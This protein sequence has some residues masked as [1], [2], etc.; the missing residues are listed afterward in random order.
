MSTPISQKGFNR[1]R[2]ELDNLKKERPE[3]AKVIQEARE[4]GDLSEN[5][6]YDAARERQGMLEA[7][8]SYIESRLPTFN[9]VDLDKLGGEKIIYGATV[10]IVDQDTDEEKEYTI[11]SPDETDLVAGGISVLSPVARALLGKEVGDDVV[12][13]A[14]RGRIHYE[15]VDLEFKGEALFN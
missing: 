9:V 4:E 7:R 5:A 6:G 3:I 2:E 12:V 13:D 11:V 14:P 1:L 10:R 15:V 8:I